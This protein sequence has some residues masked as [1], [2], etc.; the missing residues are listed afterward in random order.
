MLRSRSESRVWSKPK[1]RE[2]EEEVKEGEEDA[3]PSWSKDAIKKAKE[4][5]IRATAEVVGSE[6]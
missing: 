2:E 3:N 1:E 6:A 4:E 5:T